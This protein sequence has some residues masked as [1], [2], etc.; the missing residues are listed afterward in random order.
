MVLARG[1]EAGAFE[2][3]AIEVGVSEKVEE[4]HGELHPVTLLEV[5]V[6]R[7]L[8]IQVCIRRP[9]TRT[10]ASHVL[11]DGAEGVSHQ[12]EMLEV[13]DIVATSARIAAGGGSQCPLVSGVPGAN[14]AA[15]RTRLNAVA[16]GVI[17][18][19]ST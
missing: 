17:F 6:L 18:S 8:G 14:Q 2:S 9:I 4:V 5:P 7:E 16:A 13:N 10:A 15:Q 3:A 12:T 11:G 19:A 1:G